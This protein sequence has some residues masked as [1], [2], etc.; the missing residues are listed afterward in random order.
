VG[1]LIAGGTG[2][3]PMV[4]W[5]ARELA[6]GYRVAVLSR[7][8]GRITNGF[9]FLNVYA[10]PVTVGDEPMEL[11]LLLPDIPIAVDRNR[12]RGIR[13]LTSGKFG[14]INLIIMDDG[15]QHRRVKPGFSIVL[16]DFNRPMRSEMMLPAGLR[17]EPLSGLKRA[18]MIIVT[19]KQSVVPD[20]YPNSKIVLITGIAN[21]QR[22]ASQMQ[23]SGSLFRHLKFP[24][25]HRYTARDAALIRKTY[26]SCLDIK[27]NK[28]AVLLTTGKDFVKLSRMAEL[29]GLP[30][31]WI[32]M[33]PP[34]DSEQQQAILQKIH[35]YVE[36]TNRNG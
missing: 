32:P 7:G 29:K 17:R 27:D 14:R 15:F 4:A 23:E 24:D 2:K 9:R 18:D 13:I 21:P 35:D 33:G 36:K 34:I 19:K 6:S 26:Q 16:D 12:A 11:R 20:A 10:T 22:L 3:T 25:H 5:L 8:Y 30:L 31:K 28:P 1:N